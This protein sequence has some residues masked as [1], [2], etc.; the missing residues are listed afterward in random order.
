VPDNKT[1]VAARAYVA[2]GLAVFPLDGKRPLTEHGVKDATRDLDLIDTWFK[3]ARNIGIAIPE[4]VVIVDV[5]PRNGGYDSWL[6]WV[7]SYGGDYWTTV[8]CAATGGG[9]NHYWFRLPDGVTKLKKNPAPGIDLLTV[10]RYV[11]AP[12]SITD[13]KYKWE[14]AL[15]QDLGTLDELPGFVAALARVED[16]DERSER[17]AEW[18]VGVDRVA[19]LPG[20]DPLDAAARSMT[21]WAQLLTR[22]GWR[23]VDYAGTKWRHPQ[24][25]NDVSA[26]I[27]HDC[28]FVYSPNTP[29]PV[30]DVGDPHGITLFSALV[31]LDYDGDMQRCLDA[32]RE[33][34]LLPPLLRGTEPRELLR[35]ALGTAP[36]APDSGHE[37]GAPA[38]ARGRLVSAEGM[39]LARVRWAWDGRIPV[40]SLTLLAGREGEGKSTLAIGLGAALTRGE[41]EGEFY[42]EPKDIIIVAT[43]DSWSHTIGPRLKASNANMKRVLFWEMDDPTEVLSLPVHLPDLEME[44]AKRDVALVIMDPLLS[45]IGG[46]QRLDTHKD[47]DVRLALEPLVGFADRIHA[48][49]L[50]LIHLNKSGS[51][52]PLQAIMASRA[53]TAVARSVLFALVD[54]EDENRRLLGLV[55]SNLGR[56]D[57]P[58]MTYTFDA[59]EVGFDDGPIIGTRIAWGENAETSI[60]TALE[61]QPQHQSKVDAC[62]AWLEQF[63]VS[64]GG[65]ATAT[66]CIAAGQKF[67]KNSETGMWGNEMFPRALRRFGGEIRKAGFPAMPIYV[68]PGGSETTVFPRV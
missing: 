13:E 22:H 57:I 11:V 6:D 27:K 18:A 54:P 45:R 40:G 10:G 44:C 55:K 47:S 42:G 4:G 9:G 33:A 12:P 62:A 37:T 58:T 43:E 56:L 61:A 7:E 41:L 51:T 67:S 15:P 63:L 5:D 31:T 8:P 68:H 46:G 49:I 3:L 21:N 36:G 35:P 1:V 66:E 59:V 17:S 64:E 52:D 25:Q 26:T 50:G 65:S 39:T 29:F 16:R 48:A 32:M 24:T 53:F 19:G 38:E 2:R 28:L 14:I 34:R 30:T 20:P 60:R 23:Q